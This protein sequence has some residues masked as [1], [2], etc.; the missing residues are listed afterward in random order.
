MPGA[1]G[2]PE[3]SVFS[4]PNFVSA[5][6]HTQHAEKESTPRPRR[7][8]QRILQRSST[9]RTAQSPRNRHETCVS[10]SIGHVIPRPCSISVLSST[11]SCFSTLSPP[12]IHMEHPHHSTLLCRYQS[13]STSTTTT[14]INQGTSVVAAAAAT[15]QHL[16]SLLVCAH[17]AVALLARIDFQLVRAERGK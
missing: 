5:C 1:A 4:P 17:A 8:G 12:R 3:R 7:A 11:P 9:W 2:R 14:T 15:H 16:L 13:S 10:F 6:T